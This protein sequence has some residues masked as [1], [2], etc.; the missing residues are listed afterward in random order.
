MG[1][2]RRAGGLAWLSLVL[3]GTLGGTV[4]GDGA[5]DSVA[6]VEREFEQARREAALGI[7]RCLGWIERLYALAD[8][9]PGGDQGF[10]ALQLVVDIQSARKSG[11]IERA[12]AGA[13]ERFVAGY[14]NDL[15]RIGPLIE[16]TGNGDFVRQ[17][18][19]RTTSPAVEATCLY[20][21]V[22]GV[23]ERSYA[24]RI[25]DGD[26]ERA[27]GIARRLSGELGDLKNAGG[28][29]FRDL[30][31]GDLFQ[32]EHLRIGMPAPDIEGEDLD[33][34]PFKLSDYRGKVVVLDFWGNW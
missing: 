24:D 25:P 28:V 1:R 23:I 16:E 21:D 29:P 27:L 22:A 2:I 17:V 32:L 33:G 26:A 19:A 8:A 34:V 9:D 13:W 14:S 10:G 5:E 12:A 7:D 4:L 11:E 30:V 3:G 6:A 15:A 18:Q 31:A 20:W